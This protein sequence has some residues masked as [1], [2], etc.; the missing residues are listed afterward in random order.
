MHHRILWASL[1]LL[2]TAPSLAWGQRARRN[3]EDFLREKP[4]VGD[5]L[6][7]LIVYDTQGREVSTGSL[8]GHY[9]VITFGC[10]T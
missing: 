4:L 10:L 2:A 1:L 5:R 7:D 6:P 3:D 9:S 8:R